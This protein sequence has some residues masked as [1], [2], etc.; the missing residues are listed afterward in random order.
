VARIISIVL[1]VSVL[2]ALPRQS[3]PWATLTSKLELDAKETGLLQGLLDDF[4]LNP[5]HKTQLQ[6]RLGPHPIHQFVV[7]QAYKILEKDPAYADGKSGLPSVTDVNSWDGI[8]R[9]P[10]GPTQR[11]PETAAGVP[12]VLVGAWAFTRPALTQDVAT[13]SDRVADGAVFGILALAGAGVVAVLVLLATR[14]AL[15]SE[16]RA[17]AGR[18]LVVIAVVFGVAAVAGLALA[19]AV[20]WRL[21]IVGVVAILAAA[22]YTGGPRPYGYIGLGEVMV[23]LFFGIVATTGSARWRRR[24]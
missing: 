20:D 24:R 14:R 9:P 18:G 23:L 15:G 5:L 11:P 10:A 8:T 4:G 7:Q 12:A 3:Q 17:R 22:L 1:L 6:A 13:R 16:G 19:A 21:I 2:V